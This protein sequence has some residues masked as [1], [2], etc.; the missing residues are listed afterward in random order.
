MPEDY[1]SVGVAQMYKLMETEM[2][3]KVIDGVTQSIVKL[4]GLSKPP[5]LPDEFYLKNF[6]SEWQ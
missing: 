2:L 6:P 4:A 1:L 5:P 3:N